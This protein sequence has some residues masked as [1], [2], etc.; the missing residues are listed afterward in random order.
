[1]MAKAIGLLG[2]KTKGAQMSIPFPWQIE[3]EKQKE[4]HKEK[5]IPLHLPLFPPEKIEEL[6]DD[7]D[8]DPPRVIIIQM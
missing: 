4:T 8:K 7:K 1:M 6:K 2:K 3:K 5:L